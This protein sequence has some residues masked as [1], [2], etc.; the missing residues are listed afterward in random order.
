[1]KKVLGVDDRNTQALTM[2]GQAYLDLHDF[3]EAMTWLEK[4]VAVQPKLTQNQLNLAACLIGLRKY[5]E[6]RER[7]NTIVE[8]NPK[9]PK[10]HY[11][12]GI[13]YEEQGNPMAAIQE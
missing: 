7:L 6:A 11:H 9:F 12:L 4:A 8:S 10:A 2:I 3:P 1:C 13:L 5:E